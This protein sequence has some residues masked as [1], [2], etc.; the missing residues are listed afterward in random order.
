MTKKI[1]FFLTLLLAVMIICFS[2]ETEDYEFRTRPKQFIDTFQVVDIYTITKKQT[3]EATKDVIKNS[4]KIAKG[5]YKSKEFKK[6]LLRDV[7]LK[8]AIE[9]YII[10][11]T[12]STNW[13]YFI[14]SQK[15]ESASNEML[16]IGEKYEMELNMVIDL[17]DVHGRHFENYFMNGI[18][19]PLHG[20]A[21]Y[22]D[23]FISPNIKG[24]YY[25]R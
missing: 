12:D 23:L 3:R 9:S 5:R 22:S 14:V 15:T 1:L 18:Y 8:K 21:R 13:R 10:E 4:K 19:I 20:E 7:E 25:I 17:G 24:L 2:Q 16:V 6:F 11:V